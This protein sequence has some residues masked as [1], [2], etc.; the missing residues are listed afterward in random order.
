[1]HAEFRLNDH[2]P[3]VLEVAPRPIGGL[4]SRVLRF[5]PQRIFLEELLIRKAL[6]MPGADLEREPDAAGVMMIPVPRSGVLEKVQG[7]DEALAV[8]GISEIQITARL[9]DFIAAW[10]EGSSYL[11]FIFARG[12]T[13]D[14][15]EAALREAHRALRFT[16]APRL[17]VAH[18][19]SG[20]TLA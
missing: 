20:Q 14:F 13:P 4:C 7:A 2:G 3:W 10:P 12:G 18:P 17:P 19:I 1:V 11:G 8:P 15:V 6:A 9:H 5:G 16:I